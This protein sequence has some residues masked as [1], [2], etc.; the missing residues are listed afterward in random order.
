MSIIPAEILAADSGIGYL[1]QKSAMLMQ[2]DRIFVA[3]ATICL[4]G[5]VVDR[6]FRW[7]VDRVLSRYMSFVAL[8]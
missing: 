1:L 3:L 7:I 2:T 6:I 8:A 5:F 4:L